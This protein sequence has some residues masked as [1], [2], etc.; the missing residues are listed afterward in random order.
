MV[1]ENVFMLH[2]LLLGLFFVVLYDLLIIF[3]AVIPHN[4]F[5]VAIED[6]SFWIICA[7]Q[8]FL[9]MHRE[10][11]GTLRWFAILAALVGMLLYK[12]TLSKPLVRTISL[13][14]MKIKRFLLRPFSFIKK[15]L[16]HLGKILLQKRRS[17]HSHVKKKLTQQTK[18][19]KMMFK[20]I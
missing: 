14:L 10:S 12:T 3:R 8:V 7:I 5:F 15:Q 2:A 19:L 9:L 17:T 13:I 18:I 16:L 4:R 20:K 6:L 1:D 11:N